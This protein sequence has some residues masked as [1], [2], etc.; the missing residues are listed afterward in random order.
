MKYLARW[1]PVLA[2]LW[3]WARPYSLLLLFFSCLWGLSSIATQLSGN[4]QFSSLHLL[5]WV[6]Y[7]DL[8][9]YFFCNSPSFTSWILS[10]N[11]GLLKLAE[12]FLLFDLNFLRK[13]MGSWL[14]SSAGWFLWWEWWNSYLNLMGRICNHK[15]RNTLDLFLLLPPFFSFLSEHE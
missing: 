10:E 14:L 8:L 7:I 1:G 2:S 4:P 15:L 11:I 3:D 12:I 9:L 6:N 5:F 13:W